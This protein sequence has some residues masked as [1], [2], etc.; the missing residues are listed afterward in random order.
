MANDSNAPIESKLLIVVDPMEEAQPAVDRVVNLIERGTTGYKPDVTLLATVDLATLPSDH[1]GVYRDGLFFRDYAQRLERVGVSP[2]MLVSWAREWSDN[3]LHIAAERAATALMLSRPER[4]TN[5][6]TAISF[7]QLLRNTTIPVGIIHKSTRPVCKTILASVN[8]QD[9]SPERE[10]LNRKIIEAG[11]IFARTYG[12]TLHLVNAYGSSLSYPDRG[13][14]VAATGLPNEH[15]HLR[16][17]EPEEVLREISRELEPDIVI[18]GATHRRGI[19]AALRG[20]KMSRIFQ[21]VDRDIF[22]VV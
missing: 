2:T 12:A 6:W 19:R 11:K 18:L 20:A 5:L 15:I 16:A 3:I 4:E 21:A 9:H 1:P 8:L 17:G 13:K 7:W 22:I 14:L 10:A